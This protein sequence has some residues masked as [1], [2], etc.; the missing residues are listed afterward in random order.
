MIKAEVNENSVDLA[1]RFGGDVESLFGWLADNGL[2][3]NDA[4]TPGLELSTPVVTKEAVPTYFNERLN[5]RRIVTGE[6]VGSSGGAAFSDGFN[7]A[8]A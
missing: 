4:M 6:V 8:F 1:V 7:E 3:L 2:N 5:G